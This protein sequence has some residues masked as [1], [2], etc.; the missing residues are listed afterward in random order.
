MI[1]LEKNHGVLGGDDAPP[2]LPLPLATQ[3]LIDPDGKPD[4]FSI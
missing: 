4:Q 2:G 3:C 1:Y